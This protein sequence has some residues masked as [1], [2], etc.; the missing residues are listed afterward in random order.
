MCD[1]QKNKTQIKRTKHHL[2]AQDERWPCGSQMVGSH[3]RAVRI[4]VIENM[5]TSSSIIASR[6]FTAISGPVRRLRTNRGINFI[7]VCKKL[8]INSEDLELNAHLEDIS[9]A[10][11]FLHEVCVWERM[12]GVKQCRIKNTWWHSSLAKRG[13][14]KDQ[15]CKLEMWYCSDTLNLR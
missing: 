14:Q 9:S 8:Q 1:L 2:I 13:N 15:T 6:R 12:I 5:T 10:T 7:G 4:E 3:T 11:P